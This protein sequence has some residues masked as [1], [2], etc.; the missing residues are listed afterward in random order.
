VPVKYTIENR[1][2][3]RIGGETLTVILFRPPGLIDRIL[4]RSVPLFAG[5]FSTPMLV[6]ES[7]LREIRTNLPW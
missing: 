1:I 7:K 6:V 2:L 5:G 4:L 3:N